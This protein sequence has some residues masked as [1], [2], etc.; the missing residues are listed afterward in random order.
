MMKL[1]LIFLKY[2]R[3][4]TIKYGLKPCL[5]YANMVKMLTISMLSSN[6]YLKLSIDNRQLKAIKM[7]S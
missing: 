6:A 7:I 5:K 1:I 3:N 2:S 4:L